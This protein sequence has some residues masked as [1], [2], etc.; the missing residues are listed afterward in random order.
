M[1]IN[2]IIKSNGELEKALHSRAPE[3]YEIDDV[4]EE[5]NLTWESEEQEAE[6]K[7][8]FKSHKISNDAAKE[9]IEVNGKRDTQMMEQFGSPYDLE[10]EMETLRGSWGNN[11]DTRLQEISDYV[12]NAQ[13]PPEVFST[14]P[15][16]SAAGIQLL[17]EM[18]RNTKGPNVMRTAEVPVANL[19][20]QLSELM[21]NPLYFVQNA[22]GDKVRSQ[23]SKLS[24]QIAEK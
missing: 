1:K 18:M 10:Q 7:E 9:I 20:T 13:L 19:E 15:L 6:I 12:E 2:D 22:E 14:S 3:T 8:L 16:K 17:Y 11:T 4:L 21:N 24:A 23:A 5:Q